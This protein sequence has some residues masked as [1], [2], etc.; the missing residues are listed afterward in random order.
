MILINWEVIRNV[1]MVEYKVL[2][3]NVI[4]LMILFTL[5]KNLF[6]TTLLTIIT[7][8]NFFFHEILSLFLQW[9]VWDIILSVNLVILLLLSQNDIH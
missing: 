2:L 7:F 6:Q 4:I 8:I 1:S 3:Q 9:M 5:G